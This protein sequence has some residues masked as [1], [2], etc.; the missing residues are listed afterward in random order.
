MISTLKIQTISLGF[1]RLG[2]F[3]L[4]IISMLIPI[5]EWALIQLLGELSESSLLVLSAGLIAPVM[6]PMLIVVILLD[7]IM[8]KVRAADDPTSSGDRYRTISRVESLL[9]FD[10]V[11]IL[12]AIFH[13]PDLV[14]HQAAEKL[15]VIDQELLVK[16]DKNSW[17][18]NHCHR[19]TTIIIA[20]TASGLRSGPG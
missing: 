18:C 16:T 13:L 9:I 10:Y 2:L 7:I 11:D 12:G 5:V 20:K 4:A 15:C 8:A 17:H 19:S 14:T 6:A 1:L 3:S